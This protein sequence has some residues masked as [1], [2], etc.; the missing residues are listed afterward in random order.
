MKDR[1]TNLRSPNLVSADFRASPELI[2]HLSSRRWN[3]L[4]CLHRGTPLPSLF[5]GCAPGAPDASGCSLDTV[6]IHFRRRSTIGKAR[7]RDI[8]GSDRSER[9]PPLASR[10]KPTL[11]PRAAAGRRRRGLCQG[12]REACLRLETTI[13]DAMDDPGALAEPGLMTLGFAGILGDQHNLHSPD[14]AA[15]LSTPIRSPMRGRLI[16]PAG[17][18]MPSRL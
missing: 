9:K 6:E 1:S 18:R 8:A 5:T 2:R 16:A 14:K 12:L 15:I 7:E 13:A 17:V 11:Q 3:S 10:P 4:L